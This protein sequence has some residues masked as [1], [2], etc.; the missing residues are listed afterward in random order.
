MLP[1]NMVSEKKEITLI[2][3]RIN[4]HIKDFFQTLYQ[5]KSIIKA[6][7]SRI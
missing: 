1:K 3:I 4:T 2:P 5:Y 7:K 6:E